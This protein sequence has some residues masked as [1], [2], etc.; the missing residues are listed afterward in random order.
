[1]GTLAETRHAGD[2]KLNALVD[3]QMR[4]EEHLDRFISEVRRLVGDLNKSDGNGGESVA[5]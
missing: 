2:E 5:Q 3:A 1:M 4:T